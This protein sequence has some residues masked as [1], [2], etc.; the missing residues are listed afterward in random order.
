MRSSRLL[1]ALS[2]LLCHIGR[3]LLVFEQI[4]HEQSRGSLEEPVHQ[5]L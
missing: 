3:K 1:N 5:G 2:E 4:Q